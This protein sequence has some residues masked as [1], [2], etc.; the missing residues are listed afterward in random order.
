MQFLSP[1]MLWGLL[2]LSVPLLIHLWNGR[3]GDKVY[4]AAFRFLEENDNKPIRHIRLEH[5]LLMALRMFMLLLL[6]LLMAQLFLRFLDKEEEKKVVHLV[7]P[8]ADL[9]SE[10]KFEL[11]QAIENQ[12]PV[13][14]LNQQLEALEEKDLQT[15]RPSEIM[16][17]QTALNRLDQDKYNFKIYLSGFESS[18]DFK[19]YLISSSPEIFLS[20]FS[21]DF[22]FKNSFQIRNNQVLTVDRTSQLLEINEYRGSGDFGKRVKGSF[23]VHNQVEDIKGKRKIEAAFQAIENVYELNFEF[24][25]ESEGDILITD[26]QIPEDFNF[27]VLDFSD[28]RKN[29]QY[30]NVY[31]L[32]PIHSRSL[33]SLEEL[34]TEILRCML[35]F[36]D[37]KGE[38]I[39]LGKTEIERK[40]ILKPKNEKED[41]S[42]KANT[43]EI[44]WILFLLVLVS[45]RILAN[46]SGL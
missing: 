6:T 29:S 31:G 33:N 36:F 10:F 46:R 19:N 16:H 13:F 23:V 24:D 40:F 28:E 18:F 15:P 42:I 14:W 20:E 21:S 12:E 44:L 26:G 34:P 32:M 4:W 22:P 43:E 5:W 3:K 8:N 45:E 37:V 9:L 27:M 38:S 2:A 30:P 39:R 35:D 25:R 11:A 17:L 7:E 1:Y 41:K